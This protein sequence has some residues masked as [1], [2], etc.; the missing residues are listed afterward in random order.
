MTCRALLI[1]ADYPPTNRIS[2]LR[3]YYLAT[4]LADAGCTVDVLAEMPLAGATS[5]ERPEGGVRVKRVGASHRAVWLLK[6]LWH[7]AAASRH[8]PQIVVSS[9]G[10]F[11]THVAAA[12]AK[13]LS[14]GTFW[15]ADYRDLWAT[16]R[17]YGGTT[18]EDQEGRG[19]FRKWWERWCLHRSDLITTVSRGLQENLSRFHGR[20]VLVFYNGFEP[21]DH[22]PAGPPRGTDVITLSHTGSLYAERSP[23]GLLAAFDASANKA[24]S[25]ARSLRLLLA[26]PV[27]AQVATALERYAGREDIRYLG[28]LPR[29]DA[30]ALQASSDYCLLIEDPVAS[31]RG[32]LTGKV[33]EY[34]GMRKPIIAFGISPQSELASILETTGLA[35]FV[36]DDPRQLEAFLLAIRQAE[37]A[38]RTDPQEEVIAGYAREEISRA[39]ADEILRRQERRA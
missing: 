26:G 31:L 4:A 32:V 23:A 1:V 27:D 11:L 19:R 8:R 24:G 37:V 15:V 25:P 38:A 17:Y 18:L 6:L 35:A 39:F 20:E 2:S 9:C 29:A 3:A 10:P 28:N 16:G 22:G 34:I 33:F 14:P 5:L 30:Y 13:L 7:V 21:L 12:F 36:G